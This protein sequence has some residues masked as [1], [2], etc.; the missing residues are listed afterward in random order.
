MGTECRFTIIPA[1]HHPH[2]QTASRGL[3]C[4]E[5]VVIGTSLVT[6]WLTI[7]LPMQGM[8]VQS[9]VG[10]LRSHMRWVTTGAHLPQLLSRGVQWRP[11]AVTIKGTVIIAI[12]EFKHKTNLC[13]A[14]HQTWSSLLS[15]LNPQ[16][17]SEILHCFSYHPTNQ[18]VFTE[19][20]LLSVPADGTPSR[21]RKM[22]WWER[23]KKKNLS[24]IFWDALFPVTGRDRVSLSGSLTGV[25]HF[26]CPQH[27]Y[28]GGH[29]T[30]TLILPDSKNKYTETPYLVCFLSK[31]QC[32]SV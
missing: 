9:L 29:T 18:N 14:V 3:M 15:S 17:S 13:H 10:E 27:N 31:H 21:L 16:L 32:K 11:S 22:H 8:Q 1:F 5:I 25:L 20:F 28:S 19:C 24:Y 4:K 2:P 30:L 7:H 23:G 12:N 6:Q 26:P